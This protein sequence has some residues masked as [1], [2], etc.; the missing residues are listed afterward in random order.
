M[1]SD[2]ATARVVGGLFIVGTVAGGLGLA[3]SQQLVDASDYL[4]KLSLHEDRVATGAF[5]TLISTHALQPPELK[6][7]PV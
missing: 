3:L 7:S 1:R 4:T 5:L 2:R 6:L